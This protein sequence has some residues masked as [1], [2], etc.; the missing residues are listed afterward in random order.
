MTHDPAH[1]PR[2]R[3]WDDYA[4]CYRANVEEARRKLADARQR[5]RQLRTAGLITE[6]PEGGYVCAGPTAAQVL[7][8]V[9]RWRSDLEHWSARL[10]QAQQEARAERVMAP[11]P[12]LPP[13]RDP[14]DGD[15]EDFARE[16]G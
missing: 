9:L 7:G 4:E 11:D 10:S 1:I 8:D 12:R 6:R 5:Y 14:G 13:E 15:A 3:S 16:E 2:P